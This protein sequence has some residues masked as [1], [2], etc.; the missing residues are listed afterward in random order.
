MLNLESIAGRV[1]EMEERKSDTILNLQTLAPSVKDGLVRLSTRRGQ[2]YGMVHNGQQ[3]Y[4]EKVGIPGGFFKKCSDE[5]KRGLLEQFH[6]ENA[7]KDVMLRK[8]DG[9]IRFMASSQYSCFDDKD[10]IKALQDINM[11]LRIREFH[12]DA[13]HSIMRVTTPDPILVPNS[14]P[15]YPGLQIINSEIG[16]SSVK[17]Q[18]F[19]WEEVCTNGMVVAR[20]DFPMFTMRHVGK[21]DHA[22]L[23]EAVQGKINELPHFVGQCTTAL[24]TL[25]S[26]AGDEMKERMLRNDDIP[27]AIQMT[28]PNFLGNY[29]QDVSTATGLDYMSALTEAAQRYS[30]DDRLDLERVAGNL[31]LAVG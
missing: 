12:Q 23:S 25:N 10:V 22:R 20:G 21:K 14:R 8:L 17:V 26:M 16:N 11:D 7:N 15:F 9:N 1:G 4:L 5:N 28:I 29:A 6:A 3:S 19:L 31:M 18:F 30:W 24:N 2:D 27:K 13:G